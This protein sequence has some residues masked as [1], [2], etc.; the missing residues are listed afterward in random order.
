M[1]LQIDAAFTEDGSTHGTV[2]GQ[3]L[4]QLSG[5]VRDV[6]RTSASSDGRFEAFGH[7]APADQ[8]RLRDTF[9]ACNDIDAPVDAVRPIHI[10]SAC[11]A[12]HG[13]RAGGSAPER[14]TGRVIYA[15]VGLHLIDRNLDVVS[16]DHCR[17]PCAQEERSN[18]ERVA[19]ESIGEIDLSQ[20]FPRSVAPVAAVTASAIVFRT[21]PTSSS[22]SVLSGARRR[23]LNA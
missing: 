9:V 17:Y 10:H 22:V 15:T 7:P 11:R 3:C 13:C 12:E 21:G 1:E 20:T 6:I 19:A 8:D 2:D 5:T 14:M 4:G 23:K 16:P 18:D